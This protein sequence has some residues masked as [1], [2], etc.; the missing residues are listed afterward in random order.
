MGDQRQ[1]IAQI[2]S[3]NRFYTHILGLLDRHILA[4]DFSLTEARVLLEI[5]KG[6][7][8]EPHALADRLK[9]DRSYLSRMIKRFEAKGL[10]VKTP[11]TRDSRFVRVAATP[12]ALTVL[13]ELSLRSNA[14]VQTLLQNLAPDEVTA[15][16][17]A[18]SLIREKFTQAVYPVTFRGYREGDAEYII[19]R[20]EILYLKEYGLSEVFAGYVEQGVHRLADHLNPAK[21][22][23]LIPEVDHRPMGSIAIARVDD[24]TAQLRYFL[25]EPEARGYGLGL[26][27][28]NSALDFA[29]KVG[30]KHI[31]LETISAL[32]TARTLY[33]R[34]GF[35]LVH[36]Q[37]HAQW[38]SEVDE[39][40]W[41][42][43]L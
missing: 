21:E 22:C 38:G 14:Q 12:A 28:V 9:I 30:Y 36:S 23:F 4:T 26:R 31:F 42:M 8:S 25:L 32:T 10:V 15:V 27:M 37:R 18:M 6:K 43:D 33:R 29:R 2:R 20:H 19:R 16:L 17:E 7:G 35:Q 5:S 11:S 1:A 24:Q 40:R 39:E 13:D 3:F 34:A 41:E